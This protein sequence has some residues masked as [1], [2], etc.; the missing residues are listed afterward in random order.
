LAGCLSL[1]APSLAL[2]AP[3]HPHPVFL[4]DPFLL[5]PPAAAPHVGGRLYF[6]RKLRRR[7]GR[8]LLGAVV[9]RPFS[10]LCSCLSGPMRV[11]ARERGRRRRATRVRGG[12]RRTLRSCAQ[13]L[14]PSTPGQRART[15]FRD[16]GPLSP[17]RRGASG[18]RQLSQEALSQE[19][20]GKARTAR[21]T[22][23]GTTCVPPS[24][25]PS[26]HDS[27]SARM[28][29]QG[30]GGGERGMGKVKAPGR[31]WPAPRAAAPEPLPSW[32]FPPPLPAL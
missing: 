5:P 10:S 7:S 15:R 8:C 30:A 14:L 26:P 32:L 19:A 1:R 22:A 16:L 6:R 25:A 17:N 18:S 27:H 4:L 29:R 11:P 31:P 12:A 21:S 28:F 13:V 9:L 20:L 23:R 2:H 24:A 3:Q